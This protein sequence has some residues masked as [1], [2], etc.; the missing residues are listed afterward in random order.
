[1]AEDRRVFPRRRLIRRGR[2]VL[3]AG[4]SAIECV[5]LDISEGGAR[6]RLEDWLLVPNAFELRIENGPTH[7]VE[8]R[9]R[10]LETAGVQFAG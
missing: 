2:I 1:M 6:L 5:I 3:H 10:D 7:Q 9:H 8:V 4:R